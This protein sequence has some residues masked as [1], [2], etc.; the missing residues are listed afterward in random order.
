MPQHDTGKT[1]ARACTG[2]ALETTINHSMD[3]PQD[4][5]LFG[6]CFCPFVQRVWVALEV[7]G[8]PYS[9]SPLSNPQTLLIYFVVVLCDL[10]LS[11]VNRSFRD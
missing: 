2:A 10:F 4:I 1:Y 5:V 11:M 7:L 8:I 3:D 6:S 9:V